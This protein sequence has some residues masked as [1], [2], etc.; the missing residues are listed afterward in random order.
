MHRIF[1]CRVRHSAMYFFFFYFLAEI[2]PLSILLL[3]TY[4]RPHSSP[5]NKPRVEPSTPSVRSRFAV[6]NVFRRKEESPD[7]VH[8]AVGREES[9]NI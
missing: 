1:V 6:K 9:D 4:I 7:D 5:R 8:Q 2:N 3:S